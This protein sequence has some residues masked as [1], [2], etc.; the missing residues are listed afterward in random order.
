MDPPRVAKPASRAEVESWWRAVISGEVS[1]EGAHAWAVPIVE[2]AWVH[3]EAMV[4]HGAEMIHGLDL[5][6]DPQGNPGALKHGAA[7]G[8]VYIRSDA[9][10]VECFEYWLAEC[11]AY[12]HDPAEFRR[13]KGMAAVTWLQA[14]EP[15]RARPDAKALVRVGVISAE[16]AERALRGERPYSPGSEPS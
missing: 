14:N 10:V 16:E 3:H 15:R 6:R 1:R 9:E 4:M 11:E 2:H 13:Q 7:P 5:T 8:R 12:D